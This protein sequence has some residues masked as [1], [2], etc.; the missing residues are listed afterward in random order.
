MT[1]SKF[2][3]LMKQ[4]DSVLMHYRN[5]QVMA[6]EKFRVYKKFSSK[7]MTEVVALG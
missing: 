3:E 4:E 6:T 5:I 1:L 7:P 2:E